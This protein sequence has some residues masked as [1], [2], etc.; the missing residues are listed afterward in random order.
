[1]S[2]CLRTK[3]EGPR[4][5]EREVLTMNFGGPEFDCFSPFSLVSE[6]CYDRLIVIVTM[7]TPHASNIAP[8]PPPNIILRIFPI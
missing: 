8:P 2:S 4:T 6:C 7:T 5:S 1:M 3:S